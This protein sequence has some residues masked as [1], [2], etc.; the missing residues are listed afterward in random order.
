MRA[1]HVDPPRGGQ[2][3]A[4][5]APDAARP[6]AA[7]RLG[8]VLHAGAL[9]RERAQLGA[10]TGSF[11]LVAGGA[12]AGKILWD[13][14][15]MPNDVFGRTGVQRYKE[16]TLRHRGG[17]YLIDALDACVVSGYEGHFMP[18]E[19]ANA[20]LEELY[21][22]NITD[23]NR[24]IEYA[25]E[26]GQTRSLLYLKLMCELHEYCPPMPG[27]PPSPA[28]PPRLRPRYSDER[29]L[30]AAAPPRLRPQSSRE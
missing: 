13:Y 26:T 16:R 29:L 18:P 11:P 7:R 6:S 21:N 5:A 14:L 4:A 22:Y 9:E 23:A 10:D 17:D 25:E 12:A 28:P 15:N 20:I 3:A 30:P 24:Y 8:A 2:S 27:A 1:R 19:E